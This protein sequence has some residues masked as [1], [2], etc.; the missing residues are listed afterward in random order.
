MKLVSC[1]SSTIFWNFSENLCRTLREG[2]KNTLQG[3]LFRHFGLIRVNDILEWVAKK[4]RALLPYTMKIT[5]FN[6]N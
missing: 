5:Y 3:I 6:D 1:S 2:E 4:I